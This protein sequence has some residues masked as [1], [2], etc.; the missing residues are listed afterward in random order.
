MIKNI[1]RRLP[2]YY[3]GALEYYEMVKFWGIQ[4]LAKN[5]RAHL[6]KIPKKSETT[7]N[8]LRSRDFEHK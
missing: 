5:G 2:K 8:E 4:A 6:I 3:E 1:S 7:K